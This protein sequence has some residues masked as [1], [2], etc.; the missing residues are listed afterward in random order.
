VTRAIDE[1]RL[2]DAKRLQAQ[3]ATGNLR[4]GSRHSFGVE[5]SDDFDAEA[6]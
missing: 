3:F 1:F 5:N 2:R 6:G 4:A